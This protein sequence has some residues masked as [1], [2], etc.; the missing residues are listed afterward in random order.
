MARILSINLT[1]ANEKL[2]YKKG[3]SVTKETLKVLSSNSPY[4]DS[5]MIKLRNSFLLKDITNI[6]KEKNYKPIFKDTEIRKKTLTAV[7]EVEYPEIIYKEFE[8]LKKKSVFIY[9][10]SLATTVITTRLALDFMFFQKI[11]TQIASANLTKDIGMSRLGPSVLKN[12]DFLSKEEYE[13]IREHTFWGLILLIHYLGEGLNALIAYRHH[14]RGVHKEEKFRYLDMIV[15]VDIFNAL[16]SPR[17]FRKQ[18]FNVRG[19]LDLLTEMGE[20]GEVSLEMVK[21]LV[22]TYRE[23]YQSPDELTLSKEKL[24]FI[25]EDNFYGVKDL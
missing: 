7:G 8:Y 16:I 3:T 24:G 21:R 1:D 22:A 10:H 18:P 23:E 5:H 14:D 9:H 2:I 17:P 15:V 4:K 11:I 13:L 12:T 6:L 20:K 25:P 19:A